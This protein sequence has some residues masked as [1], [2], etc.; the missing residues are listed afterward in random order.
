MCFI[1][2]GGSR[3]F[4]RTV[5]AELYG[6][7]PQRVIGSSNGL[8]FTDDEQGGALTL[9]GAG[10]PRR[11]AGQAGADLEP[12]R[13]TADPPAGNSNGDIRCSPGREA[14]SGRPCGCS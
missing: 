3:D 14:P 13:A 9:G 7:P 12:H 10:R 4:M 6:V 8:R 11:R 1:A 2:S 5:T